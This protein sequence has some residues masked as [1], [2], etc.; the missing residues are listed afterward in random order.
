[1]F[2][3]NEASKRLRRDQFKVEILNWLVTIGGS[4]D[5]VEISSLDQKIWSVLEAEGIVVS[6]D[7]QTLRAQFR[8]GFLDFHE[9]SKLIE[10]RLATLEE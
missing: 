4:S 3:P 8:D 10:T 6:V 2:D 9:Y 1:V 7:E 5:P